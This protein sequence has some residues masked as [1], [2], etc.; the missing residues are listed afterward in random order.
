MSAIHRAARPRERRPRPRYLPWDQRIEPG[1]TLRV[2][3]GVD[4]PR[5][6]EVQKQLGET[7]DL[8]A[9]PFLLE[10]EISVDG[11]RQTVRSA[12]FL[13]QDIHMVAT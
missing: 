6:G 1:A 9:H 13:R 2:S 12:E 11:E 3:Y 5:W 10:L 4:A 8:L 7:T